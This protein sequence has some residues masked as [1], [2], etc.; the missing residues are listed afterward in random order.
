MPLDELGGHG[1][2]KTC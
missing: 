1:M 2:L